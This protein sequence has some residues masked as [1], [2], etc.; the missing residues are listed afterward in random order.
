MEYFACHTQS[1]SDQ[2]YERLHPYQERGLS[3]FWHGLA[4]PDRR[5]T[6]A[7]WAFE[8]LDDL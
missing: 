6:F 7:N 1:S 2:K 8:F 4:R 3:K 5:H